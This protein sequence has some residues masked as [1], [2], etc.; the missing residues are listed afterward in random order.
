MS[1]QHNIIIR[2]CVSF[3]FL[4][5]QWSSLTNAWYQRDMGQQCFD[6]DHEDELDPE[7]WAQTC[8]VVQ[9]EGGG[10]VGASTS[11]ICASR[12]F[13]CVWLHLLSCV[14]YFITWIYTFV[15]VSDRKWC[16]AHLRYLSLFFIV[17]GLSGV[18]GVWCLVSL[19]SGV[20]GVLCRLRPVV[21]SIGDPEESQAVCQTRGGICAFLYV[22]VCMYVCIFVAR[23]VVA[24]RHCRWDETQCVRRSEVR[25]TTLVRPPARH[26][27]LNTILYHTIIQYHAIP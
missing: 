9:T 24:S 19:V 5:D 18:S 17:F 15:D 16:F 8:L 13:V 21:V 27:P 14:L 1:G 23:L 25:S 26:T 10:A 11:S 7:L 22:C 20:S 3:V 6:P 4:T 2:L 12:Y